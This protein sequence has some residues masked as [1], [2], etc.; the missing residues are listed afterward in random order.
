MAEPK[1]QAHIVCPGCGALIKLQAIVTEVP[2]KSGITKDEILLCFPSALRKFLN[3]TLHEK[4]AHI[5]VT[6]KFNKARFSKIS[7]EI[8]GYGGKYVKGYFVFPLAGLTEN[9]K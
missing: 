3:V 7:S 8:R 6:G 4:F 9:G 1:Q 2:I 5:S